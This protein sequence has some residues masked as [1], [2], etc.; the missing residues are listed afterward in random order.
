MQKKLKKCFLLA[1][2][3][4]SLL[5][6]RAQSPVPGKV[7]HA[8]TGEP[9]PNATVIK[10]KSNVSAR[11]DADGSF[12]IAV[13]AGDVLIVSSVGYRTTE[14][15]IGNNPGTALV[16]RLQTDSSSLGEVV[17]VGYGTQEKRN[18]STAVVTV[19]GDAIGRQAVSSVDQAL[20][21]QASGVQV[22]APTGQ[23]GSSISVRIRGNNSISLSNDPLYVIDGVPLVPQYALS[24]SGSQP[25]NPL[26]TINPA[27]IES[28]DI[29]KDGA[30]AAIYGLRAANGVVV[31]TTKRGKA[32]K[33]EV[34]FS[35]SYGRQH[36][37]KKIDLLNP[38]QWATLYNEQLTHAGNPAAID[39]DTLKYNT[40]WQ[41]KI[42]RSAPMQ[43]YQVGLRGGSE[44]NKYYFSGGYFSQDGIVLNSGI[45][46]YQFKLNLDQTVSQY[47][48]IGTSINFS[49]TDDN[50]SV[51][52]ES[53]LNNGGV[54]LGALS[55]IPVIPVKYDN[56][57]YATNPYQY[58]DNP[59]GNLVEVR[60]R[61]K[62]YQIVGN[63]YAELDI[64]K[65]LSFRTSLG[66][67]YT[68]QL[69]QNFTT[70]EYSATQNNASRGTAA[71]YSATSVIGIWENT[72]TYKTRIGDKQDLTVLAGYSAQSSDYLIQKNTSQ[73]FISN[74]TQNFDAASTIYPGTSNEE[75]WGL[76][77]YFGRAIYN[78]DNRYLFQASLR[79]DGS[80]R[81][82]KE[83]R[84]GYF[85]AASFGWRISNE[86]FF[87]GVNTVSNLKLRLSAGVNGN[88]GV[89][90]YA[91][92]T[93]YTPGQN[94]APLTNLG[95]ADLKWETTA[96][97]DAGVDIG[98]FRDILSFTVD[99]YLKRTRNLLLA[100][101]V[102]SVTGVATVYQNVGTIENKGL[103]LSINSN[104]VRKG[105]FSWTTNLNVSLNRSKVI[106]LGT[107]QVNEQ[108]TDR[109]ILT[110]KNIVEKGQPLGVFYGYV[111]QGIFQN[112]DDITKAALQS[113]AKPGDIRFANL[114][115]DNV[116]DDKDRTVI[117]NPNP[118]F[119]GGLTNNFRYKDFELSIFFQ[120]SFG[121]DIYNSTRQVL[122]AMTTANNA[123][124]R[125]LHRW[126]KE[127]DH[128]DV[129]RAI[130]GDPNSN[131][132]TSSRFV[133][134]GT[135]V[136]LKN[137]TLG[138]NLPAA[139][140]GKIKMNG[141]RLY[142]TGQN[143]LTIT[144]YSGWDPEVSANPTNAIGFGE[145]YAVYPQARTLVI[146]LHVKL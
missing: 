75:K 10:K 89:P 38:R 123:S 44:K 4:L 70:R 125:V 140:L 79:A 20:Q 130:A 142:V 97:Y 65:N 14:Y 50:R 55:A 81:F 13:S 98:L 35:A 53:A 96:Q 144:K 139:I 112:Q 17:V 114:A 2:G 26:N 95:N 6:V 85:P 143:L 27:D 101:P 134:K 110:G 83:H 126:G 29:L 46:R 122:D 107:T 118:R 66:L 56:G 88:Q 33:S 78:Y 36:L 19:K 57:K 71:M 30:S 136:R 49:R 42:F 103:E 132:R 120:G 131:A 109:K 124:T 137:L 102:P 51:Q 5:V 45:K 24:G 43:N 52:S 25:F 99:A 76:V 61:S 135:Y 119:F 100:V 16:I 8:Q 94:G 141:I 106:D 18:V 54:L 58:A 3:L 108:L 77:S 7:I 68:S 60:N 37:I 47:A 91:Q 121:N 116:I 93:Y 115:S 117:A 74:S 32:G 64:L 82:T 15:K 9:V 129:P 104:N 1:L 87:Q 73:G 41:D 48:R 138:Y 69:T 22:T 86:R 23:P 11:A 80:S 72:L 84:Y 111:A 39:P 105:N 146:G 133:E 12:S 127:G 31:I 21:G 34:D 145:D 40:D 28:I 113:N 92:Y 62:F 67:D 90:T 63:A 59:V 128:T